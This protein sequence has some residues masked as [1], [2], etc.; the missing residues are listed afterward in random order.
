MASSSEKI[1]K[2]SQGKVRKLEMFVIINKNS[3][4]RLETTFDQDRL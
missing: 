3:G 2:I 4:V 1:C